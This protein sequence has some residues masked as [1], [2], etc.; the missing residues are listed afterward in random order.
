MTNFMIVNDLFDHSLCRQ[1]RILLKI[2][3]FYIT[4]GNS[5]FEPKE[6]WFNFLINKQMKLAQEAKRHRQSV[7][8]N[9]VDPNRDNC[10]LLFPP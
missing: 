8:V 2:Q 7:E 9:V 4:S 5:N 1:Y 6:N 10:V 3:A